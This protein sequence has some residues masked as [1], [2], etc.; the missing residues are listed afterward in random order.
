MEPLSSLSSCVLKDQEIC[1]DE[2]QSWPGSGFAYLFNSHYDLGACLT[3]PA[4]ELERLRSPPVNCVHGEVE[5]QQEHSNALKRWS[6]MHLTFVSLPNAVVHQIIAI[7]HMD[8]NREHEELVR[9]VQE[10]PLSQYDGRPDGQ[11]RQ[12]KVK[13]EGHDLCGR[14]GKGKS[15]YVTAPG[16]TFPLTHQDWEDVHLVGAEVIV[17]EVS[18]SS[19]RHQEAVSERGGH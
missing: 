11:E 6:D 1:L 16:Q 4:V 2:L 5:C 10:L 9:G 7:P 8:E 15:L 13:Y 12:E 19:I 14:E 3:Y 17:Q 18:L